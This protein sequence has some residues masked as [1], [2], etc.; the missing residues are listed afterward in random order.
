MNKSHN[1]NSTDSFVI[2]NASS[3]TIMSTSLDISLLKPSLA[4]DKVRRFRSKHSK[5]WKPRPS[6]L[7][8]GNIQK[9]SFV[10]GVDPLNY[11][12]QDR[13][14]GYQKPRM[15]FPHNNLSLLHNMVPDDR[16]STLKKNVSGSEQVIKKFLQMRALA[17]YVGDLV[18]PFIPSKESYLITTKRTSTAPARSNSNNEL[19]VMMNLYAFV[20]F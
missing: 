16:S 19:A 14:L 3:D 6:V 18:A 12:E 9:D 1:N 4:Q 15:W 10:P 17:S 20:V 8:A 7:F 13:K 2:S 5:T 11:I